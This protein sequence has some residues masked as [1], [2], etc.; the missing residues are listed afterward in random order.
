[1]ANAG[2]T[3][4]TLTHGEVFK[5]NKLLEVPEMHAKMCSM[6]P[7]DAAIHMTGLLGFHV[8]HHNL[9][10]SA[11]VI[12]KPLKFQLRARKQYVRASKPNR[13][14]QIILLGRALLSLYDSL[15]EAPPPDLL[16]LIRPTMPPHNTGAQ[17]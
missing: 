7:E 4:N 13:D 14:D 2:R 3:T 12:G 5:L 11:K 15:S 6:T 8:T 17:S 1:M 16:N 9:R 10:A